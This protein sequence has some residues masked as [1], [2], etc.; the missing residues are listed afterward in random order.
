MGS[1]PLTALAAVAL[2]ALAAI[3]YF[4]RLD[5]S[6]AY[7]THDEV[8]YALQS[9][10]IA[11]NGRDLNG[12]LLPL[13]FP[14]QGYDA[15]RDPSAI[16]ATAIVLRAMPL[17]ER[18]IRL[19][20]VFIGLLDLVL[21]FFVARRLFGRDAYGLCAAALLMLTPAHFLHAREATAV[22]YPVPFVLA[23]LLALSVFVQRPSGAALLAASTALGLGIFSYIAALV[24]MPLLLLYT[25]WTA[26]RAGFRRWMAPLAVGA[27]VPIAL[28]V[29]WYVTHPSRVDDIAHTYNIYDTRALSPVQGLKNLL[30]YFSLGV[31]MDTY[32]NFFNPSFLFISGPPDVTGSARNAGVFVLSLGVL[33]PLGI[34]HALSARRTAQSQAIVLGFL[35]APLAALIVAQVAIHRA[36]AIVPFGVLLAMF[37]VEWLMTSRR[38]ALRAA[39]VVLLLAVP[40]SFGVFYRDYFARY[41]LHAAGALEYNMRGAVE[42]ILSREPAH[43]ARP[44]YISDQVLWADAYWPFY[45]LVHRRPDLVDAMR[46]FHADG[47]DLAHRFPPGSLVLVPASDAAGLTRGAPH[48]VTPIP[49]PSGTPPQLA[50]VELGR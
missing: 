7:L 13:Y 17:S 11:K 25:A 19:P 22:L 50:V 8:K 49:E 43:G 15:G 41:R 45:A 2:A 37:G 1:R 16:Y 47:S 34:Y 4:H 30:S 12:R 29:L 3:L 26:M 6:P 48:H 32:W 40:V 44:V 21:M 42:E 10:S 18:A 14:E 33:L 20:S 36:L 35:T 24:Q 23:W 27:G 39:A 38:T 31:R 5:D 28:L 46:G 9:Y